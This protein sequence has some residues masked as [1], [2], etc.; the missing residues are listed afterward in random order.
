MSKSETKPHSAEFFKEFRDYWW[1][2]DFLELMGRR[3]SFENVSRVLDVGCGVGHW[4]RFLAPHLT[5]D[6]KLVGI[7]REEKWIRQATQHASRMGLGARYRYERGDATSIP[8][9]RESFDMVT[10]QT[11]LIHLKDPRQGL[12]EMLRVLKP[13]GLLLLAEPNNFANRAVMNSLTEKLSVDEVM[14]RMKFELVVERGKKA[15]GLG[16]NSLGDFVPGYLVEL[17]ATQIG[18]HQSDK[19]QP[20]FP[21]YMSPDQK[22][23]LALYREWVERQFIGWDRDE[24]RGYFLA[25]GGSEAEFERLYAMQVRDGEEIIKAVDAG[26]YHTAGGGVFYLISARAV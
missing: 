7:D 9:E 24:V 17:G 6:T 21:P 12:R 26:T 15:L 16:Y 2:A 1:N 19:G 5:S 10:C 4:G 22:A 18:V 20:I 14:D 25:G 11:V 23:S 13:G 3:L 8:F